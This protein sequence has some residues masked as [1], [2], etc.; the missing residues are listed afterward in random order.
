VDF[1]SLPDEKYKWI[2]NYQDHHTKFISLFPL[3]SKRVVKVASNFLTIFLTFGTPE[4]LQSDNG[5]VFVNSVNNE[6]KE[7]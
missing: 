6:I 5:R 1:Q 7:L 3:E 4:I 2:L